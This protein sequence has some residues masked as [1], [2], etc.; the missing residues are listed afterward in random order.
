MNDILCYKVELFVCCSGKWNEW[1]TV[2]E[3]GV[4]GVL[5]RKVEEWGTV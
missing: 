3:S 5:C 2:K 1:C 4:N